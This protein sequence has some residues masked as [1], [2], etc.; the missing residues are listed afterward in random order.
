MRFLIAFILIIILFIL[1]QTRSSSFV[2]PSV[3]PKIIWSFWDSD[4]IPD[5]ITKC[6][7]SWKEFNPDWKINMITKNSLKDYVGEEEANNIINW[8]FNDSPQ[9]FSDLVR[10]S[11][12]AKFGGLWLDA[13][14]VCFKSFDWIYEEKS[15]S[16]VFSI[17]EL[18]TDPTIESWFIAAVPE[19]PYVVA[20]NNEFRGIDQY[21]SIN[22]YIEKSGTNQDAIAYN[23]NYLVIYLCARKV[24]H[25]LGQDSVRIL[26]AS[27]GPYN[28]MLKGGIRSLCDEKKSFA[29]F[30][31]DERA[32]M[33]ETVEKCIFT[34]TKQ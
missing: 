19:N 20:W 22:E 25:D 2:E 7:D 23:V 16:I 29:K 11:V 14:I 24:Y 21:S 5:F 27:D 3:I 4:E 18:S 6:T 28:Y 26:S 12:I 8:K 9:R 1:L 13:S 15:D 33:N 34:S 10:L 32:V 30:R 31:K 17:K